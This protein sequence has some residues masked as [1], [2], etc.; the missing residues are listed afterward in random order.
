MPAPEV[1]PIE[2]A[3][4]AA[5]RVLSEHGVQAL[6]YGPTEGF[7]PLRQFISDRMNRY[8]ITA[9]S[10]NV[11]ITTGSQQALDLIDAQSDVMIGVL[12]GRGGW[13]FLRRARPWGCKTQGPDPHCC[14]PGP[15]TKPRTRTFGSS[16]PLI[17]EDPEPLRALDRMC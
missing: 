11:F 3:Q 10:S 8:G 7:P 2:R 17:D 9:K 15:T 14:G 12:H 5:C 16:A 13:A 4:E 1:L 6:Q